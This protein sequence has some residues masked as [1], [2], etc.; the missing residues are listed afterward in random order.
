MGNSPEQQKEQEKKQNQTK[1]RFSKRKK[2]RKMAARAHEYDGRVVDVHHKNLR[3]MG[4]RD[5][6]H[7]LE[8]CSSSS[9]C[10]YRCSCIYFL[11]FQNKNHVY[12]GRDMTKY[13]PGAKVPP[14][15][16]LLPPP[17]SLLPPPSSLLPPCPSLPSSLSPSFSLFPSLPL[18]PPGVKIWESIQRKR[19]WN[20]RRKGTKV[21]KLF[22]FFSRINGWFESITGVFMNLNYNFNEYF[23]Y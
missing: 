7:W 14:P 13:I 10:C 8:V 20:S 1:Q 15:S 9:S 11:Y 4:Y 12:V 19:W 23:W 6:E 21:W 5:L 18:F 2:E 17:S 22:D 3:K 16:S